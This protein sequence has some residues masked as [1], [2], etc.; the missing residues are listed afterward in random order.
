MNL[1][2]SLP[3]AW[4]EHES[5]AAALP[6]AGQEHVSLAA[7]LPGAGQEHVSLVVPH[8][9]H[10]VHMPVLLHPHHLAMDVLNT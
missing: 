4:Q 3:G 10:M 6:G 5:L 2:A 7:A 1:A 8:V 9:V